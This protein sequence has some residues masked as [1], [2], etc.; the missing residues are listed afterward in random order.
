MEVCGIMY[1]IIA[2]NTTDQ[3]MIFDDLHHFDLAAS[4]SVNLLEYFNNTEIARSDDLVLKISSGDLIVNNGF[5]DLDA[6]EGIRY[7]SLYKHLNPTTDD[8]REII[9]ADT[10]PLGTQT[11]FSMSGDDIENDIIGEGKLM[12]WDFSNDDDL[13]DPNDF[14]NPR[15][16]AS[17]MK[18][19]LIDL[20]F[21]HDVYLKDGAIYFFDAPWGC[22]CEMYIIVPSVTYYPNPNGPIP[23]AALGLSGTGKY[24]YSTK[25]VMYATYVQKHLMYR[26]CPMG[27]E[28]NAEGATTDPI[29]PGW[30]MSAM[31]VTPESDTGLKGYGA[32]E[33]YRATIGLV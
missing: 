31:I 33:M 7:I 3:V 10:R 18:A 32:F 8:G 26:D 4:G 1:T 9:R 28:L 14:E 29:P 20:Y 30:S 5:R 17:G 24:A 13:Y 21:F 25:R 11:Y 12:A 6:S 15:S 27:D 23:A 22:Y 16:V 19:K 2:R